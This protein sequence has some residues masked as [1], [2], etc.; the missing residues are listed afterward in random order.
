MTIG[1]FCGG[2]NHKEGIDYYLSNFDWSL[3]EAS[4]INYRYGKWPGDIKIESKNRK[5]IIPRVKGNTIWKI[6]RYVMAFQGYWMLN[7]CRLCP[8]QLSD[9]ADI[10][11][12]DPHLPRFKRNSNDGYSAVVTRSEEGHQI[13]HKILSESAKKAA[14]L[15][16]KDIIDSQGHTLENRKN[17]AAYIKISKILGLKVPIYNTMA[18]STTSKGTTLDISNCRHGQD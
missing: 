14:E 8:D 5:S 3:G 6:M 12:G 18:T 13:F 16:E 4:K 10:S 7:R 1:L 2:I 15:S 11:V 9:L 17:V